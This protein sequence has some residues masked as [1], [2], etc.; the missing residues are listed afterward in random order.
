[1]R[2]RS[3]TASTVKVAC[4]IASRSAGVGPSVSS[5]QATSTWRQLSSLAS[6]VQTAPISGLV[7]RGI[8]GGWN[9]GSRVQDTQCQVAR[10]L[11]VVQA[12]RGDRDARRHL[13]DRQQ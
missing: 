12:D 6:S 10:V 7:Y 5:A 3:W 11:G 13:D 8:M 9:A 4:A 2:S 1:M